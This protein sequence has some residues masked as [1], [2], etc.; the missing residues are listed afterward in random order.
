[1]QGVFD[2]CLIR[3]VSVFTVILGLYLLWMPSGL[4]AEHAEPSPGF[5]KISFAVLRQLAREAKPELWRVAK[6]ENR[7][8]KLYLHWSAMP[9]GKLYDSYHINIDADGSLYLAGNSLGEVRAHTYLR[10]RGAI[11]ITITACQGAVPKDLGEQPPTGPQIEAMAKAIAVLAEALQL[12]IDPEH[13]MTHGEAGD[14]MDRLF[15]PY[16]DNG[17]PYGMYGPFHT[18]ERWDLAVLSDS[19]RWGSGG[20]LLRMK[21]NRY[22]VALRYGKWQIT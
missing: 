9:Y 14:N 8:V 11:G 4:A 21:A 5:S 7:D 2:K 22:L 20:F 1:M 18:M 17:V 12:P 16:E 6:E 3:S 15:P 13:V 10:N 19:D